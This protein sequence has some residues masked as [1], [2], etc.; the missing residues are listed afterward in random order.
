MSKH[1]GIRGLAA[2]AFSVF[3]AASSARA[4]SRSSLTDLTPPPAEPA[5]VCT[6]SFSL[7]GPT[8]C[9]PQ[10]LWDEYAREDC[11]ARGY[12]VIGA[13]SYLDACWKG[14][15]SVDYTCCN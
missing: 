4:D 9:K 8:S 5:S 7:G 2:F 3:V 11:T 13:V 15:R 10:A 12:P 6:A 14:F 1:H